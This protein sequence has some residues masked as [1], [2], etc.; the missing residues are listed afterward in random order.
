MNALAEIDMKMP[1]PSVKNNIF[2]RLK[3]AKR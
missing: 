1:P 2:A 3:R